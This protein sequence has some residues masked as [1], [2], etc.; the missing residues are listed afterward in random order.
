[1]EKPGTRRHASLPPTHAPLIAP[2]PRASRE[3]RWRR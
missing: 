2:R 1:M 3:R